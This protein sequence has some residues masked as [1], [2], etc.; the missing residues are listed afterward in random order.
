MPAKK[1]P[2]Q[3]NFVRAWFEHH[4]NR[5]IHHDESK[6]AIEEAWLKLT[7]KRLEDVD[8]AIR[9]LGQEG[10]LI[11]V[12]KGVYRYDPSQVNVR[13]LEDFTASQKK[14]ILER[15]GY[16]CVICGLGE[17]EGMDLQVD[18]IRP[19]ELDGKAV[20]SNGQTLCARH[21]FM[22][23]IAS[24]T[25]TGKKMFIRLLQAAKE[26]DDE[27]KEQLIAFCED[28][29]SV[30]EKHGINGHIEWKK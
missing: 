18:H 10:I 7:G 27:N 3:A 19:K 8:R 5:D 28:I 11:K 14:E 29:L 13:V 24:Q 20:V 30:F 9:R 1:M 26:G 16:K 2:S 22:K 15:D 6:K 25:E 12:A 21:N 4:P 17:R 23:K